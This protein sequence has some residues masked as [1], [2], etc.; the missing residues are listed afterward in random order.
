MEIILDSNESNYSN[1]VKDSKTDFDLHLAQ[2]S[3]LLEG[4]LNELKD[5]KVSHTAILATNNEITTELTALREDVTS[6]FQNQSQRLPELNNL[7]D[8][9][10][11]L[12]TA[13][14]EIAM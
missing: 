10:A 8:S 2:L 6:H 3:M 4:V 1:A 12:L 5:L 13:G 11:A 9:H 14:C 7:K